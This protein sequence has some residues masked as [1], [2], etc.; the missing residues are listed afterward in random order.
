MPVNL[1]TR[2]RNPRVPAMPPFAP[3]HGAITSP[4]FIQYAR[5][6]YAHQCESLGEHESQY[7]SECAMYGDA[8]VGQGLAVRRMRADLAGMVARYESLTGRPLW[9]DA[10]PFDS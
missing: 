8:G 1:N 2:P 9:L 10:D 3:R 7:L 4:E 5:E 6:V